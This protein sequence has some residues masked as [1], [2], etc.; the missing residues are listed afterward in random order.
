[1]G[2]III[3]QT[4]YFE[5]SIA[6]EISCTFCIINNF[7]HSGPGGGGGADS[8]LPPPHR[9]FFIVNANQMKL[10]TIVNWYKLYILVV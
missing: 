6:G 7:E 8:T 9:I 3:L 2:P 10:C 4:S 5:S 1:M